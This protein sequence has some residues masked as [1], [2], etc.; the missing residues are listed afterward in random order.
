MSFILLV[1]RK[2]YI[3]NL[4]SAQIIMNI[5]QYTKYDEEE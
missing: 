1:A 2:N 4:S 3:T 5:A